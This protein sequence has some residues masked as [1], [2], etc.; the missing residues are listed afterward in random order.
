[1]RIPFLKFKLRIMSSHLLDVREHE[2]HMLMSS[3][4]SL[5]EHI[6]MQRK[7]LKSE[8]QALHA[9]YAIAQLQAVFDAKVALCEHLRKE[10]TRLSVQE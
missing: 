5:S 7:K 4:V 9:K 8:I 1:M 6:Q 10:H 3:I 2:L